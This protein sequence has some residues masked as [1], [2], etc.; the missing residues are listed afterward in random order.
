MIQAATMTDLAWWNEI[1]ASDE[2]E[3]VVDRWFA[4]DVEWARGCRELRTWLTD[5]ELD[6]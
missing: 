4:H 1:A 5:R 3:R 2:I 6:G